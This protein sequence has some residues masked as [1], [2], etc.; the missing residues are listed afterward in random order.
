MS[1][2]TCFHHCGDWGLQI[3]DLRPLWALLL[4]AYRLCVR[5]MV[6]CQGVTH[7]SLQLK[8]SS[9]RN[10]MFTDKFWHSVCYNRFVESSL[11]CVSCWQMLYFKI[12]SQVN[13]MP[14]L[15]S[16]G[17]SLV[18]SVFISAH[19][20][21]RIVSHRSSHDICKMIHQIQKTSQ[22]TSGSGR[23][24]VQEPTPRPPDLEAPVIQFGGPVYNLRAKNDF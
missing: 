5:G 2:L 19:M 6:A 10:F 3:H 18:A 1:P 16:S 4:W 20:I 24:G 17:P 13:N 11:L 9:L 22:A 14:S 15:H 8:L 7:H 12:C 23:K 21:K